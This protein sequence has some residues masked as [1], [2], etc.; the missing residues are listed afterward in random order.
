[1]GKHIKTQLD[2]EMIEQLAQEVARLDPK[3]EV[4]KRFASMNN[5]EGAELRKSIAD[6]VPTREYG[7]LCTDCRPS[8]VFEKGY[9]SYDAVNR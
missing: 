5:Y 2:Y 1:M 4:L 7:R 9:P 8:P 6:V 3:N